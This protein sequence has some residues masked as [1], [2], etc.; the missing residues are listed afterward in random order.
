MVK[1]VHLGVSMKY[2]YC[3]FQFH[4]KAWFHHRSLFCISV[5]YYLADPVGYP[6]CNLVD[7]QDDDRADSPVGNRADSQ[8]DSRA[9]YLVLADMAAV[10][11]LV[12]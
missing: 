3:S 2:A 8:V 9:D 5:G 12:H 1:V 4:M 6:V 10:L 11:A 7:N